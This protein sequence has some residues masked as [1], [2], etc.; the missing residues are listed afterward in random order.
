MPAHVTCGP[1]CVTLW[2]LGFWERAQNTALAADFI[3][4]NKQSLSDPKVYVLPAYTRLNKPVCTCAG[5]FA[6]L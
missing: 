3:V 1:H 5:L 6:S 4:I 2:G